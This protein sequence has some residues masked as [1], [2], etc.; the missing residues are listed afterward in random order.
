MQEKKTVQ[1]LP[2]VS[3]SGIVNAQQHIIQQEIGQ[4][5]GRWLGH[6]PLGLLSAVVVPHGLPDMSLIT[7][8]HVRRYNPVDNSINMCLT[9]RETVT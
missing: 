3:E 5:S 6:V 8:V 2:T 4:T 7:L 1:S 9:L